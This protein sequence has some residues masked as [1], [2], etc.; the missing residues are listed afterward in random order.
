VVV[1]EGERCVRIVA[2][3]GRDATKRIAARGLDEHDIGAEIGQQP[4]AVGPDRA[5]QIE[6]PDAVERSGSERR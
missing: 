6:H 4:C 1:G 5:A 2:V 3:E